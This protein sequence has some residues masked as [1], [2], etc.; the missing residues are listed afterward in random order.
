MESSSSG[1]FVTRIPHA[2]CTVALFAL[3]D[4]TVRTA[5]IA[6]F[7]GGTT[8]IFPFVGLLRSTGR[9]HVVARQAREAFRFASRSGVAS[10][11]QVA[12]NRLDQLLMIPLVSPRQLGLYAVAVNVSS[13]AVIAVGAIVSVVNPR[14][15]RGDLGA[16]AQALRVTL[17]FVLVANLLLAAISPILVPLIFGQPFALAVPMVEIL[18]VASLPGAGVWVL[19]GIMQSAGH[20]G[21]P[22]RSEVAAVVITV[23]GLVLLLPALGGIGAAIVSLAAYSAEFCDPACDRETCD[24]DTPTRPAHRPH[25]RRSPCHRPAPPHAARLA[26]IHRS[27]GGGLSGR[28][29]EMTS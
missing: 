8:V 3:G 1:L 6:T 13:L 5:A 12:N 2:C 25:K 10:L 22:A 7:V 27:G 9:P 29:S 15:A 24:S 4:L 20:P 11:A 26:L 18:L 19:G 23:A 14:V 28:G 16:G 17:A 21:V